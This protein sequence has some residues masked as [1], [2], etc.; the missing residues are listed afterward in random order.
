M[1]LCLRFIRQELTDSYAEAKNIFRG[2]GAYRRFK[3]MLQ[4]EGL[5][6]K[7]YKFEQESVEQALREWCEENGLR[8]IENSTS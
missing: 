7:W 6:Q 3:Q 1:V 8:V 4:S 2:T 5:L